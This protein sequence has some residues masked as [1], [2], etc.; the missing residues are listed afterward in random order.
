MAQEY[1]VNYLKSVLAAV[2]QFQDVLKQFLELHERSEIAPGIAPA[3]VPKAGA[4]VDVIANL[5]TELNRLA[6][7]A[8][9][10]AHIA[11]GMLWVQGTA[12]QIDPIVNWRS[13]TEPKPIV[14]DTTVL[15]TTDYV[16]G[17][18]TAMIAKVSAAEPPS[19]GPSS[20]HHVVWG[21]ARKLWIDGHYRQ[22]V[23]VACDMAEQYVRSLTD[24][25]KEPGTSVMNNA[26]SPNQPR[27]GERRLRWPGDPNHQSVKS[28]IDG[29]VRYA[30]GIQLTIRNQATHN[31]ST[32][33][34]EQEALERL[35]A[36]SLLLRWVDECDVLEFGPEDSSD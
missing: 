35:A 17:R 19:I 20:L 9:E 24:Q 5:R 25:Y 29:L 33:Y 7:E 12:G 36:L 34:T 23:L 11:D 28:M 30:P 1:K 16:I 14:D 13:M 2:T 6:G 31:Q 10:A 32:E 22:A 18:L 4:D 15:D 21:A 27:A 3:V 26:F 8:S